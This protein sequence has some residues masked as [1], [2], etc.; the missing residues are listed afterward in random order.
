LDRKTMADLAMNEG[1]IFTT[2]IA[3]AKAALPA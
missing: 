3:Q 2:V 1:A